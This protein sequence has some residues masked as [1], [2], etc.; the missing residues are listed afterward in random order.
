MTSNIAENIH[1][2]HKDLGH[3]KYYHYSQEEMFALWPRWSDHLLSGENGEL[4]QT[5]WFNSTKTDC[6]Q[7]IRSDWYIW[8]IV[9]SLCDGISRFLFEL[10]AGTHRSNLWRLFHYFIPIPAAPFEKQAHLSS[11]HLMEQKGMETR[12]IK[13][14]PMQMTPSSVSL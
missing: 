4:P 5:M 3:S 9:C 14:Q 8:S 6:T 1:C 13:G 11:T 7:S 2:L 10:V 12:N